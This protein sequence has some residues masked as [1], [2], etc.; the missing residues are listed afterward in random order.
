MLF[1]LRLA[2][3]AFAKIRQNFAITLTQETK[4]NFNFKT[5]FVM[6]KL[7]TNSLA[8]FT[9]LAFV[10]CKEPKVATD[11]SNPVDSTAV[12]TPPVDSAQVAP[13][14]AEI[15]PEANATEVKT[16]ESKPEAPKTEAK[17]DESSKEAK[18]LTPEKPM[19]Q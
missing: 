9:V 15:K 18:A 1:I 13:E 11:N 12:A 14:A 6:K 5:P 7:I 17:S 16:E 8:A 2:Y 19:Q 3:K 4:P 10:A